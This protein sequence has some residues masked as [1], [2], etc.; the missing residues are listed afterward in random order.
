MRRILIALAAFAVVSPTGPAHAQICTPFT[1]VAASDPFCGNIQWLFNRGVTLGCHA[2]GQPPACCPGLFVRRDQMA[3]FLIRLADQAVFQQGGNA[4][5][6]A[7]ELGTTDDQALEVIVN[8]SRVMRFEPRLDG[9]GP[10]ILGGHP[11]NF[12]A[13]AAEGATI[14]G[15]GSES[16]PNRVMDRYGTIGGGR[17]N[18]AGDDDPSVQTGVFAT[19]GGGS[20]NVASG[21]T[22]TVAG[23]L[24]NTASATASAVG[25]GN[26]NALRVR[27]ALKSRIFP[28]F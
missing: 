10:N 25:G 24:S 4:F 27:V 26:G 28:G 3:A 6:V 1:D 5:G 21:Q 18:Q 14:G 22:S 8:N 17:N 13:A 7:A 2:Q 23:G 11:G 9:E 19:V 16:R 20:S 15:G 12:V